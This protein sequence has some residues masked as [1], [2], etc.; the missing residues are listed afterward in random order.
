MKLED[1]SKETLDTLRRTLAGSAIAA[2]AVF[3]VAACD[4]T[5]TEEPGLDDD[6]GVEAPEG[7]LEE[8]PEDGLEGDE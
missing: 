7:G 4:D 6:P 1:I 8:A 5:A 2:V 3:G